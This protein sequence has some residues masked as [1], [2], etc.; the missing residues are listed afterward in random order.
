MQRALREYR[1]EGIQT[2]LKFF[3][4]VLNDPEF[5]SGQFDTGFI[6]QWMKNRTTPSPP[7][8]VERDLAI[9]SAILAEVER[10]RSAAAPLPVTNNAT[11]RLWK[12]TG[13]LRSLRQ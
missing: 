9:I 4:E 11:S 1:V 6:E 5:R 7:S 2:N 13:R 10:V 12:T 3:A 8:Q